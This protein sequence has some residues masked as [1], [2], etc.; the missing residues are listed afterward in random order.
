MKG[1]CKSRRSYTC[2]DPSLLLFWT[3]I[4]IGCDFKSLEF[5]QSL[6]ARNS[7][8]SPKGPKGPKKSTSS[9]N[10]ELSSAKATSARK[11]CTWLRSTP[12]HDQTPGFMTWTTWWHGQ[13][14]MFSSCSHLPKLTQGSCCV[15]ILERNN[16]AWHT[17]W[18][19]LY[20]TSANPAS[21]LRGDTFTHDLHL[22]LF[23]DL[24]TQPDTREKEEEKTLKKRTK[25]VWANQNPCQWQHSKL[26]VLGP[27]G[28]YG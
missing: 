3:K 26:V 15:I 24:T 25:Q 6:E 28:Y 17:R 18:L 20:Q 14:D 23:D 5:C 2:G 10:P 12:R 16:I 13:K 9:G 7:L 19:L 22:R 1:H 21:H 4:S 8:K 27:M 11:S